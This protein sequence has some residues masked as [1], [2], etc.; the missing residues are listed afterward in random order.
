MF[1]SQLTPVVKYI[2]LINVG[3]F[4]LLMLTGNETLSDFLA[5]H[6][7][8][9]PDFQVY[10]IVTHMF[11]HGSLMH[12]FGNMFALFMF[13]PSLERVWGSKRFLLFYFVCGIGAA[14]LYTGVNAFEFH[15]I[16][17][18]ISA[19]K[20]DPD[21]YTYEVILFKNFEM[22]KAVNPYPYY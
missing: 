19:Y 5:L 8:A 22:Y 9:S 17:E 12:L 18:K 16:K 2:L 21:P 13:G 3:V 7:F 10:Q 14:L 20:A 11:M 1:G 6:Y 4:L 15:Q